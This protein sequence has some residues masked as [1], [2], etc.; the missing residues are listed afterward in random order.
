MR[1]PF[2]CVLIL[3]GCLHAPAAPAL[4]PDAELRL[5]FSRLLADPEKLDDAVRFAAERHLDPQERRALA[6][7]AHAGHLKRRAFV[8]AARLAKTF[9]LGQAAIHADFGLQHLDALR[10][11]SESGEH[12]AE[13]GGSGYREAA[14]QA[15]VAEG[16]IGCEL[17]PE[18][19]DG[20]LV[21]AD[22]L[23]FRKTSLDDEPFGPLLDAGCP[24][25][26]EWRSLILNQAF[27]LGKDAFVLR[28]GA[29]SDWPTERKAI[30]IERYLISK[31]CAAGLKAIAAFG[32]PSDSVSE[33]L[34]KSDCGPDPIVAQ[35]LALPREDAKAYFLASVRANRFPLAVAFLGVLGFGTE[36]KRFMFDEALTRG[37]GPELVRAIVQTPG[38]NDDLMRHAFD[39]GRYRFVGTFAAG[40]DWQRKAF[41][42]L[43]ELKQYDFA[44]EVAEAGISETLRTEGIIMAFQAAMAAGDFRLG[45]YFLAR[46]G[47]DAKRF[48]VI[49][50]EM[51]DEAQRV[52]F[53]KKML[54]EP[55]RPPPKPKAKTKP[56][57]K[58]DDWDVRRCKE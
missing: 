11:I 14:R 26:A 6:M 5:A 40:L 31:R 49:T 55:P 38:L 39:Q 10:A 18:P 19:A 29:Q 34:A 36:D 52:Y 46:N 41:D 33:L 58:T 4:A 23:L 7:L 9:G 24:F 12:R 8:A 50:Q 56:C 47:P 43:I 32:V 27:D 20:E 54:E 30:I 28:H 3:A 57:P 53:E 13:D 42:K 45:R 37:H 16:A 22:M 51:Y 25:D 15:L 35:G 17:S 1:I 48:R 21:V 2:A 44:G